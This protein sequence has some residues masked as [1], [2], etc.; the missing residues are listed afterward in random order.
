V[1]GIIES[2]AISS[3]EEPILLRL[4][5]ILSLPVGLLHAYPPGI[6]DPP[7]HEEV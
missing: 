4:C 3:H 6:V 7:A 5:A 2:M 1:Y